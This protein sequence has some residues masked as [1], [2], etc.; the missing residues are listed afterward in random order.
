MP[1]IF[2]KKRL[3]LIDQMAA[4]KEIKIFGIYYIFMISNHSD[5]NTLRDGKLLLENTMRNNSYETYVYTEI[6]Q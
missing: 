6:N 1:R 2:K 4:R 3:L 5:P